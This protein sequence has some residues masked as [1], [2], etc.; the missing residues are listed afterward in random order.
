VSVGRFGLQFNVDYRVTVLVVLWALGWSMIALGVLVHLKPRVFAIVGALMVAGHNLLDGVAAAA[1]GAFAPLWN[2]LHVPGILY[3]DG[4]HFVVVAYPVV[5]WIGVAALGY[6]LGQVYE[7]DAAPRRRL[8][9]AIGL[10]ACAAFVALR[11]VNLY[12]DPQPWA[13]QS[14]PLHTVL[15]FLNTS[16]YPPS[17]LFVL[18]TL[19]PA[20]VLLAALDGARARAWTPALT[21]GRVPLF[22]Y[23]LHFP[24][25]HL[26]AT[27]LCYVRYQ[28]VHWMFE[29]PTL[30]QFPYTQPPNWPLPLGAVWFAWAVVVAAMY[31]LCVWYA[32][33]KSRRS[34]WWLRYL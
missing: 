22:Y 18:M 7:W 5:P 9:R 6:G 20:L 28:A 11:A 2:V 15:S 8:L 24:L 27:A 33:L 31:P 3:A 29:S 32:D 10:G 19:G 17:L 25:I 26:L 30:G 13:V 16:K 21:I 1:F 12:G 23:L 4:T 34:D 14:T